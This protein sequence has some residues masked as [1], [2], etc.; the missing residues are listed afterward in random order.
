MDTAD[1][2]ALPRL[3]ASY[4]LKRPADFCHPTGIGENRVERAGESHARIA[5]A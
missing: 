3:P 5:P 1:H 4:Q 2:R